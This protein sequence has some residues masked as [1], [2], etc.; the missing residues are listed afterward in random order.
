MPGAPNSPPKPTEAPPPP[1]AIPPERKALRRLAPC[2]VALNLEMWK[3][4]PSAELVDPLV[5]A[6]TAFGT[7]DMLNTEQA[8][9]QLSIRFAEP[10]WPTMP[11]PFRDLRVSI[12]APMPPSWDPDHAAE[13]AEKDRRK[14]A[15][16][17]DLQLALVK[18]SVADSVKRG[19]PS[20]DLA[21]HAAG[22]ESALAAGGP[23]P[24]FWEHVDAVWTAVRDRYPMPTRPGAVRATPP[25]PP[26]ASDA[27]A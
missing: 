2:R 1:V 17:A 11:V 23:D 26:A 10:R 3:G 5:R 4:A 14:M 25:P 18:A 21:V 12:P 7:G 19:V 27:P 16:F 24:V 6:E 8:L 22:A 9:D 20:E 15:R 13:P